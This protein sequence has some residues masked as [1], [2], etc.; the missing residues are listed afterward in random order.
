MPVAPPVSRLGVGFPLHADPTFLELVRPILEEDA[1]FFEVS[2][3]TT[4]RVE[5][6]GLVRNGFHALFADLVARTRKPVVGHGL[7]FSLATPLQG[8]EARTDA[9]LSR[10]KDDHGVFHFEWLSDHLG[11]T[12]AGGLW[13]TLPLPLPQTD[14]TVAVVA[15]RLHRLA[16][17]VPTVA[18]ENNV[19]YFATSDARAEPKFLNAIA[20][21]ADCRVVLD[22]HNVWTQC[23]NFG[24]DAGEVLN[25][26][27]LDLVIEIH[28][29]GGSDSEP[30]WL[31]SG[32]TFRLDSHDA[33]VPEPV[34][35]LLEKTLPRCKNVRG[36]AVERMNGSVK[37]DGLRALRDEM[38]RAKE[39]WRGVFGATAAGVAHAR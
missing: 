8:D 37:P 3:E 39:M 11:F 5:G 30:S 34:W 23:K 6:G 17:L 31:K 15:S 36:L 38:R 33:P 7:A 22:L 21:A 24:L 18:F 16:E 1:D 10:L 13:A 25:A 2:P 28:V 32:K 20:K 29:S 9:W 12:V 26:L 19:A 27:D 14:E 4:W 35:A